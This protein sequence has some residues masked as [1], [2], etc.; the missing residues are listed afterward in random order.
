VRWGVGENISR[1]KDLVKEDDE[2]EVPYT[3]R[4]DKNDCERRDKIKNDVMFSC[5]EFFCAKQLL[6][7]LRFHLSRIVTFDLSVLRLLCHLARDLACRD[8]AAGCN[9]SIH[10][11]TVLI[12]R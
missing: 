3:I 9:S 2:R 12:T 8:R 4:G 1:L 11:N 10:L 5:L 7:F 6:Q